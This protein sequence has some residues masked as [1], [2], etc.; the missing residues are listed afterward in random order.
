MEKMYLVSSPSADHASLRGSRNHSQYAGASSS[1]QVRFQEDSLV[2]RRI[3]D[4]PTHPPDCSR[5][6]NLY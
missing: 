5:E 3:L 4:H 2:R 6:S 1:N